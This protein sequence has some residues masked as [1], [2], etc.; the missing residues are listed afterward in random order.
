MF[1][2]SCIC[3]LR[4]EDSASAPRQGGPFRSNLR[5]WH[6]RRVLLLWQLPVHQ[7]LL[8]AALPSPG[9]AELLALVLFCPAD[10]EDVGLAGGFPGVRRLQV[11][12]D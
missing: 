5:R 10:D 3:G 6:L 4:G 7:A 2:T 8:L 1:K 9:R 12:A 11:R